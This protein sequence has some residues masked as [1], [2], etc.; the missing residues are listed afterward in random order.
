MV[1]IQNPSHGLPPDPGSIQPGDPSQSALS[2]AET[3]RSADPAGTALP[4]DLPSGAVPTTTSSPHARRGELAL[5]AQAA[6]QLSESRIGTLPEAIR[7]PQ[8][9]AADGSMN[10]SSQ[11]AVSDATDLKSIDMQNLMD[12]HQQAIATLTNIAESH[13]DTAENLIDNMK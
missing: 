6:R 7:D 12:K 5:Q 11:W 13:G 10:P 8:P 1:N 4:A 2:V 9:G 3:V